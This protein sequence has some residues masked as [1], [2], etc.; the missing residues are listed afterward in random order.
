MIESFSNLILEGPKPAQ[1]GDDPSEKQN[2]REA[3]DYFDRSLSRA[4]THVGKKLLANPGIV[5]NRLKIKAAIT[6][7]RAFLRPGGIWQFRCLHLEFEC[8]HEKFVE[9]KGLA[10]QHS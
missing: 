8:S 3:F 10:G 9:G 5:R 2:Y 6:N 4:T 7:A 1:L